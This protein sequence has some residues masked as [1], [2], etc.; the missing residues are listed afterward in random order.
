MREFWGRHKKTIKNIGAVSLSI[1]AFIFMGVS[2][3]KGILGENEYDQLIA[4]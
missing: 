3:L 2:A 1:V 4:E